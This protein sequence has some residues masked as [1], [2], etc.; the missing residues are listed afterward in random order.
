MLLV[1]LVIRTTERNLCYSANY[2][3]QCKSHGPGFISDMTMSFMK[4]GMIIWNFGV[5]SQIDVNEQRE[6]YKAIIIPTLP[7]F[8]TNTSHI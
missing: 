2:S 3:V 4:R 6:E 8:E 7:Y 5:D 1:N